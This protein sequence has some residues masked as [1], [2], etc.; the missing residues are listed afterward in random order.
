[1]VFDVKHARDFGGCL[2]ILL[3]YALEGIVLKY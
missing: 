2:G 3:G 1:M